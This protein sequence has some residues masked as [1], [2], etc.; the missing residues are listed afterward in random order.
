MSVD[1]IPRN[2][3]FFDAWPQY[4]DFPF[5][6]IITISTFDF[7]DCSILWCIYVAPGSCEG[8]DDTDIC[9][10]TDC[11]TF[12]TGCACDWLIEES[13]TG[14]GLPCST[15]SG[16]FIHPVVV[17][18]CIM[19]PIW[20]GT[21]CWGGCP[22]IIGCCGIDCIECTDGWYCGCICGAPWVTIGKADCWPATLVGWFVVCVGATCTWAE[23]TAVT[24][25]SV[26]IFTPDIGMGCCATCC[27]GLV[28]E[29]ADGSC[30]CDCWLCWEIAE[31]VGDEVEAC[32][33]VGCKG[34]KPVAACILWS[35][36]VWCYVVSGKCP[37][38][39]GR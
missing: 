19:L 18:A 36:A 10:W 26:I 24:G 7:P 28:Y 2:L 20:S 9:C 32:P 5:P 38:E 6:N 29:V 27:N 11:C 15:A 21:C 31:G 8:C 23:E 12:E 33:S 16:E 14:P 25:V 30:C 1:S 35:P 34:A 4:F 3:S 22:E 37:P 39:W 17:V 13:M